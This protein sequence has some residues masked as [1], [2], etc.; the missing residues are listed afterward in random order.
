MSVYNIDVVTDF[1]SQPDFISPTGAVRSVKLS[2]QGY[3]SSQGEE[4]Q[5]AAFTFAYLVAENNSHID[6]LILSREKDDPVIEVPQ[7]LA[8]GILRSDNTQ[9]ASYA[10]YKNAGNP[11]YTA[12]AS[13]IAGVD[14]TTLLAPR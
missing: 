3:T 14:L 4:L 6:G 7:G 5:A 10:Y 2:E 12:K 8:N 1:L 11:E 9:K 13:A